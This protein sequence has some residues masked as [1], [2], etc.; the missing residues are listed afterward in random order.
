[1]AAVV[2]DDMISEYREAFQLIDVDGSGTINAEEIETLLIK[3]GRKPNAEQLKAM[4]NK[5]SIY[6]CYVCMYVRMYVCMCVCM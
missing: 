1:M 2:D 3:L 6:L 5:V 4:I